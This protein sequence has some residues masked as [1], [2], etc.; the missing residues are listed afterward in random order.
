[1]E[2]RWFY[3][4]L[5]PISVLLLSYF[6]Q[7][8]D[9]LLI[10]PSFYYLRFH[11]GE[12]M[13]IPGLSLHRYAYFSFACYC[14]G[15]LL[16][17]LYAGGITDGFG[18]RKALLLIQAIR[19]AS[20]FFCAIGFYW[21]SLLIY[22]FGSFL[23][24]ISSS[25]STVGLA[26]VSDLYE[27]PL[28]RLR[29]YG[30]FTISDGAIMAI[31]FFLSATLQFHTIEPSF[32][33]VLLY[34]FSGI[35]LFFLYLLIYYN[36][37]ETS[38]IDHTWKWGPWMKSIRGF[39]TLLKEP[40]MK[41]IVSLHFLNVFGM[42]SLTVKASSELIPLIG[43]SKLLLLFG[44]FVA[45]WAVAS[46]FLLPKMILFLKSK[47]I[48]ISCFASMGILNLFY[49]MFPSLFF[50]VAVMILSGFVL[51]FLFTLL[52]WMISE[53]TTFEIRG[54]ALSIAHFFFGLALALGMLLNNT[55]YTLFIGLLIALFFRPKLEIKGR[56]KWQ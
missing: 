39:W 42:T 29:G 31:F 14:T 55:P 52:P 38:S 32:P 26:S 51:G 30:L 21:V 33:P 28:Q 24:G 10:L 48:L 13:S 49:L 15:L 34:L 2:N 41:W 18:R 4:A 54:H 5:S 53:I 50:S 36:F 27:N 47:W 22:F 40:Q 20:F 6:F 19:T 35:I 3:F 8:L 56:L 46:G 25:F 43:E 37:P 7:A 1:M 23:C 44:L 9:F 17:A 12:M 11:F 45:C 16:F